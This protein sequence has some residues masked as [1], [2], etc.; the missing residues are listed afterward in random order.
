M[1]TGRVCRS[2]S[3]TGA[4]DYITKP[5]DN[6]EVPA[7]VESNLH[8]IPAGITEIQLDSEPLDKGGF[9]FAVKSGFS[10]KIQCAL[11]L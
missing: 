8:G 2:H 1:A 10:I 3:R 9:V 4:D 5:F 6:R 11:F 7:R